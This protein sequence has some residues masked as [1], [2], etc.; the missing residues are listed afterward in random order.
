MSGILILEDDMERIKAFRSGLVGG[1]PLHVV[2]SAKDAIKA[3]QGGDW[4]FVFLDHDLGEK[5]IV[6]DGSLV[7]AWVSEHRDKFV[8]TVFMVHSLNQEAGERM[9]NI[10]FRAGLTVHRKAFVWKE[11]TTLDR[12]VAQMKKSTHGSV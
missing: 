11:Q 1:A 3:L 9:T 12:V 8:R 5:S 4:D 10:L 2:H 7:A 6:G